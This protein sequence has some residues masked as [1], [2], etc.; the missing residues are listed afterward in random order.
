MDREAFYRIFFLLAALW[1]WAI[2]VPFVF[3]WK[4]MAINFGITVP[5]SPLW[6]ELFCWLV[7]ILGIGYFLVSRN[8]HKNHGVVFIGLLSK[9]TVFLYFAYY[10]FIGEI[11]VLLF[12][13][14][15]VDFI[16]ACI[17]IEFLIHY[18]LKKS[19]ESVA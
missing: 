2:G 5:N 18:D 6:I 7:V 3:I 9:I 19:S 10:L 8:I 1:N 4:S 13:M 16:F 12:L 14:S 17:M 11:N 15:V